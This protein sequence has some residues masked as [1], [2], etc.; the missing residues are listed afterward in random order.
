MTGAIPAHQRINPQVVE[1][2][3]DNLVPSGD[4]FLRIDLTETDVIERAA[5][6]VLS[7]ALL[8]TL[9]DRPLEVKIDPGS[10]EWIAT[11]GLAFALANRPGKTVIDGEARTFAASP[12]TREWHPAHVEPMRAMMQS[13]KLFAPSIL[14]ETDTTPDLFG[15]TFAAFVNPHLTRPNLQ[16]HPLT[17]LLWPWLDRL[18][19]RGQDGVNSERRRGWI[20]DVGRVI[21]EVVSNVCEHAQPQAGEQTKSLVLVSVTR[22]GGERSTNRLHLGIQDTGPGIPATARPKV[23]ASA[24]A[25]LTEGQLVSRLLEG[26]LAPWGRGRGQG[27]PRVVD[28]TREHA[29]TLRVATKTTRAYIDGNVLNAAV[30]V[31]EARFRLDGTVIALTLPVPNL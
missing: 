15:P 23:A 26:T 21:D 25:A 16:H 4:G 22:G 12:W 28:I 5:G 8:G 30:R 24:A 1:E 13:H 29:G 27:L 31:A 14:G 10:S 19:P 6:G 7:N 3:L 11:S 9:G 18:I 20:A 2:L 17:T